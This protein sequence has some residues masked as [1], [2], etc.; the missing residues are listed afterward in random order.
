MDAGESC[1]GA[2]DHVSNATKETLE[3]GDANDV[4][5][6]VKQGSVYGK[7][8]KFAHRDDFDIIVI[9]SAKGDFP[10]YEIRPNLARVVRDAHWTVL[11]VGECTN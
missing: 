11:I 5:V 6:H 3:H 2:K 9:A 7:I 10:N 1:A 4:A 8:L